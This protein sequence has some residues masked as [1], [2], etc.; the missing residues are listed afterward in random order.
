MIRQ[1]PERKFESVLEMNVQP[2][3]L[4]QNQV[5]LYIS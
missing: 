3:L 1:E 4:W 5:C 2:D